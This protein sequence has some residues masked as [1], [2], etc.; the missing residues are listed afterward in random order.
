MII[1]ITL[2]LHQKNVIAHVLYRDNTLIVYTLC[3]EC[4][5]NCVNGNNNEKKKKRD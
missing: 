3:R 1:D 2:K 5:V 4:I